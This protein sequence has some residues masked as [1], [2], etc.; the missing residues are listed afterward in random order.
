MATFPVD[1]HLPRL[2]ADHFL[3]AAQVAVFLA[4]ALLPEATFVAGPVAMLI[5]G[6]VIIW[7]PPAFA[8][9]AL[10]LP[11]L[12]PAHWIGENFLIPLFGFNW[13]AMDWLL[14]F[15]A[16]SLG[17]RMA[18][19]RRPLWRSTRLNGPMVFYLLAMVLAAIVGVQHG[20]GIQRVLADLR[21]FGYY[22]TF[23]VVVATLQE[24]RHLVW[25]VAALLVSG[26]IG[27][28]PEI[29]GALARTQVDKQ[30]GEQLAFG[31]IVG[32]HEVNYPVL[33]C[34]GA[35]VLATAK[36][37]WERTL[38]IAT[39]IVGGIALLLSYT[40]GSWLAAAAGLGWITLMMSLHERS[41]P[42][43]LRRTG[44]SLLAGFVILGGLSAS[45]ILSLD[46]VVRR[47]L[48]T[49]TT[50]IDISSL[51]RLTEWGLAVKIFLDA[52]I[53]GAGLGFVYEFWAIGVGS[54]SQPFIHNSYLYVLSKSGI[55][56][57]AAFLWLLAAALRTGLSVWRE[58]TEDLR[59]YG[60]LW[61]TVLIVYMVKSI[62][63]WHLNSVTTSQFVGAMLGVIAMVE[64]LGRSETSER[65]A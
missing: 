9:V 33:V 54:S 23:F 59:R 65:Q 3:I 17:L 42:G 40:R 25:I 61:T 39:I 47:V 16:M 44:F 29:V 21:L 55:I 43:A 60:L 41:L 30:T 2:T 22:V 15:G 6:G 20:H 8:A 45:G 36:R 11:L 53:F 13:Y 24:K 10:S 12:V 50:T 63:T 18:L 27:A 28:I 62:T 34:F 58:G 19:E 14:L 51:Q 35:A 32:T 5:A 1:V 56:G 37:T 4:A 64:V 48:A 57:A 26:M 49:S 31:R 46:T 52:P 38:S 7:S